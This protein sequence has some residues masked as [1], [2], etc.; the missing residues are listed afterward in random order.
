VPS[1]IY[2][3][4]VGANATM[5]VLKMTL[6]LHAFN[7]GSVKIYLIFGQENKIIFMLILQ[8]EYTVSYFC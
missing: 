2:A 8:M 7:A 1:K 5:L 6:C 3:A 4:G